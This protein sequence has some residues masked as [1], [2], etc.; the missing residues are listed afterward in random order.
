MTEET[1]GKLWGESS[2]KKKECRCIECGALFNS[3]EGLAK[4]K[5]RRCE[6][7]EEVE[8]GFD[9]LLGA[10]I[11]KFYFETDVSRMESK[12]NRILVLTKH[13]VRIE[14]SFENARQGIFIVENYQRYA[15]WVW[16]KTE[17]LEKKFM[18]LQDAKIEKFYVISGVFSPKCRALIVTN[19]DRKLFERAIETSHGG[20]VAREIC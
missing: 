11:K 17:E 1:V 15:D 18:I 4:D 13:G 12:C 5:C 19:S 2:L 14:L 8:R 9:F 16:C 10:R 6:E 7:Q 20:L 3:L